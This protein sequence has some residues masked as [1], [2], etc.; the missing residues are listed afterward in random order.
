LAARESEFVLGR[1]VE[2]IGSRS[3]K[4][5]FGPGDL[6]T[7]PYSVL[8]FHMAIFGRTGVGKSGLTD[9]LIQNDIER[10]R[11]FIL[12]DGVGATFEHAVNVLS[13]RLLELDLEQR[14]APVGLKQWFQQRKEAFA[15]RYIIVDFLKPDPQW[16]WNL[17]EVIPPLRVSEV[18]AD[19]IDAFSRMTDGEM[20]EQLRRLQ[21]VRAIASVLVE[22]GDSV[23]RDALDALVLRSEDWQTLIEFL[24]SE[25][26]RRGGPQRDDAVLMYL[27]SYFTQIQNNRDL[28]A[29]TQSTWNGIG[30]IAGD[31]VAARF[32]SSRK[33]TLDF[34]SVLDGHK[35]LLIRLPPGLDVLT[36]RVLGSLILN[37]I[38]L[39]AS[40]RDIRAVATG[41]LPRI[42]FYID[43][44]AAFAG[45]RFTQDLTRIRNWGIAVVAAAQHCRQEPWHTVEGAALYEAMRGNMGNAV[46]FRVPMSMA[47]AEAD[48]IFNPEGSRV[49]HVLEEVTETRGTSNSHGSSA[50]SSRNTS[51]SMSSSE[52]SGYANGSSDGST[53]SEDGLHR[54]TNVGFNQSDSHQRG[55]ST[56]T[57]DSFGWSE[58]TSWQRSESHSRSTKERRDYYSMQEES[59]LGAQ[60]IAGLPAREAYAVLGTDDREVYRIRTLDVP[61]EWEL[62]WGGKDY[63][64]ELLRLAAPPPPEPEPV[65]SLAQRLQRLYRERRR[66][67]REVRPVRAV[68]GG[69]RL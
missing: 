29:L 4:M 39:L 30:V 66:R 31:P 64:E 69:K 26:I 68:A 2:A 47:R 22:L 10:G 25:R 11:P 21:V 3:G 8:A 53:T 61:V 20:T 19:F 63:K 57:S 59:E 45:K 51:N 56:S 44:F 43:E 33:S 37:R 54:S 13:M 40:K 38:A 55:S 1:V 32:T 12:L 9:F 58:G 16:R 49:A 41:K 7:V 60:A 52:S 27:A 50:S 14:R 36:Q 42:T 17:F 67:D 65:E 18:V 5:R 24:R 35:C 48:A 15:Q 46:L 23:L 34:Q 62:R 28:Q 6:L